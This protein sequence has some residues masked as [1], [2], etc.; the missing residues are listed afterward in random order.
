[1]KLAPITLFVYNR[2]EHTKRTVEALLENELASKSDLIIYSDGNKTELDQKAVQEVRTYI[3]SITGFKSLTIVE[4]EKNFGLA[5]SIIEGV[6]E[7]INRY[8]SIIVL[9]DDILVSN[10]FLEFMNTSLNKYEKEDSVASIHGWSWSIDTKDIKEETYFLKDPGCWSWATWKRGWELFNP[11]GKALLDELVKKNLTFSFDYFGT[12]NYTQMLM[13]QI[14]GKNN[15]WAIRFY[16]SL[17]LK[18]KLTLHPTN[19]LVKNIGLDNS[20]THTSYD[21]YLETNELNQ[22]KNIN[23]SKEIKE[24]KRIKKKISEYLYNSYHLKMVYYEN[25]MYQKIKYLLWSVL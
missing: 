18:N 3:K 1:M 19:S 4:R 9:E 12:Y 22:N 15:S 24:N 6:T 21:K 10:A 23:F 8:E 5:K 11:N 7:V 2:L 17:F 16:A 13:E 25:L 20:G 14:E